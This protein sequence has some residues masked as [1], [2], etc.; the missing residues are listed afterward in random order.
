MR[1]HD[2]R[3]TCGSLL[4][5]RGVRVEVAAAWLGHDA[6]ILLKVYSHAFAEDHAATAKT[7]GEA[8]G[9]ASPDAM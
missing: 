9:S 5:A 4:R 6:T 8:L 3:H 7:L 2:A 1:L